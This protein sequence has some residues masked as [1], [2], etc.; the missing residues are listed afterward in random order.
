MQIQLTGQ[1]IDITPPIREFVDNKFDR[2]ER[3]ADKISKIHVILHVDKLRQI[4]EATVLM[5]GNEI[6]ARAESENLYSAI[7][8]LIDKL[9]RQLTKHKEKLDEHR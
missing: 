4:A 5:H 1:N 8:A 7:D 2:F 3:F 9:M 6:H